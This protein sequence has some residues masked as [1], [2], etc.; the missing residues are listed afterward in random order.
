MTNFTKTLITGV[1]LTLGTAATTQA[2][3]TTFTVALKQDTTI[4][5]EQNY[6]ALQTQ[7]RIACQKD[8]VRAGFRKSDI[9]ARQLR[10]CEKSI[11]SQVIKS[12]KD[13]NLTFVHNETWGITPK[14]KSYAQK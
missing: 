12:S 7:A 4:S 3:D 8:A 1:I 5:A 6:A 9:T 13:M 2:A 11:L 14:T 10:T